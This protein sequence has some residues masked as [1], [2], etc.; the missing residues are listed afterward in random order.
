MKNTKQS[1]ELLRSMKISP[2]ESIHTFKI[3]K[4]VQVGTVEGNVAFWKY[5]GVDEI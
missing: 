5:L 2:T 4:V 3:T 1:I